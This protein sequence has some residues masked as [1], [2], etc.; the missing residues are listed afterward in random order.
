MA[1]EQ[2]ELVGACKAFGL[3]TGEIVSKYLL[4]GV[5]STVIGM[6]AGTFAARFF[7]EV[8]ALNSYGVYY[9]FDITKPSWS[10]RPTVIVLVSGVLISVL[11]T[12][13]ACGRLLRSPATVLMRPKVPAGGNG[14]KRGRKHLFPLYFRAIVMNILR[15]WKRVTVTVVCVGYCCAL[16]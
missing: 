1:D 5:S 13:I 2:R 11:A 15:D 4:Y 9:T 12:L 16:S 8:F 3:R 14:R 10:V 6:A 7:F